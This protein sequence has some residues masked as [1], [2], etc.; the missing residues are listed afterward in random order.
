MSEYAKYLPF[1]LLSLLFC[2]AAFAG[3]V[4]AAPKLLGKNLKSTSVATISE[5]LNES[6]PLPIGRDQF[7]EWSDRIISGALV[8]ADHD[9]QRFALAS[10][11]LQLG[12]TDAF[13]PDRHFVAQLRKVAA[14]QTAH[15]MAQEFKAAAQAR[16]AA[17]AAANPDAAKPLSDAVPDVTAKAGIKLAV[18]K[19]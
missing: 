12:P 6:R 18:T 3:L 13:K 16:F 7:I 11:V 14:N 19:T 2:A 15:T 4:G 5:Q 8:D 1:V 17:E 9:S 10:M